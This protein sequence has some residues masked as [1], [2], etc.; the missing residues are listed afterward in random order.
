MVVRW[1]TDRC[2][3]T[4][5]CLEKVNIS[6]TKVVIDHPYSTHCSHFTLC[7]Q[8]VSSVM[9]WSAIKDQKTTTDRTLSASWKVLLLLPSGVPRRLRTPGIGHTLLPHSHFF[10]YEY[11]LQVF[12]FRTCDPK[13][14]ES[15]AY[16][17]KLVIVL[18]LRA[19]FSVLVQ[20]WTAESSFPT[21]RLVRGKN[22]GHSSR[23]KIKNRSPAQ[24]EENGCLFVTEAEN[25]LSVERAERVKDEKPT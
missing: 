4:G 3:S 22:A 7:E 24:Y 2:R 18:A 5:Q 16:T 13:Y 1:Y 8:Y 19:L 20:Y 6:F 21:L 14:S 10:R 17:P 15:R 25:V 9:F 11:F 23:K 12:W